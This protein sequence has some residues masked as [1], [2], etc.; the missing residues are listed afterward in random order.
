MPADELKWAQYIHDEAGRLSDI[1]EGLLNVSRI[2]SG[3]VDVAL[4]ELSFRDIVR[5][6]VESFEESAKEHPIS[7]EGDIERA[8][9][10]DLGKLIE[11]L[12]NLVDNAVKYSPGGGPV[13]IAAETAGQQLRVTVRDEGLGIPAES[14]SRLFQRFGRIARPETEHIRSTG[15]GLYVVKQYVELMGGEVAVESTEG[16]GSAFSFSIPLATQSAEAAA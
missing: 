5:P 13:R 6:V 11:V 1:I 2:D 7:V 15:L 4:A 14:L 9:V 3:G 16:E 12:R 8:V 10:A